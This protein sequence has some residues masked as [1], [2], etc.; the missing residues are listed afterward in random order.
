MG[1]L[2]I[3]GR[4]P[5][6]LPRPP[7]PP[8]RPRPNNPRPPP[9]PCPILTKSGP[10]FES[11]LAEINALIL[12]SDNFFFFSNIDFSTIKF[13]VEVS[14]MSLDNLTDVTVIFVLELRRD[15]IFIL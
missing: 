8:L 15:C 3:L 13:L 4:P 11:L 1:D 12:L 9:I 14:F 5:I 7:L 6:I 2:G 10:S